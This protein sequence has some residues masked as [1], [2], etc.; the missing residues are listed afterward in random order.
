V[1]KNAKYF[2]QVEIS[3]HHEYAKVEHI[4][5][6]ADLLYDK[7]VNV[8]ANVMIDPSA[9]EKCQGLVTMLR[10]SKRRWPIL[11]MAVH[12]DGESKYND[13]QLTYFKKKLK[14]IPNLFWWFTLKYAVRTKLW[15]I[16]DFKKKRVQD[17][18]FLLNGKNKFKGWQCNLGVDHI[19]LSMTGD[20]GGTCKEMIYNTTPYN[21][22]SAN[23]TEVFNPVIKPTVCSKDK[24][25]CGNEIAISKKVIP[26]I[27]G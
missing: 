9:F 25:L 7:K 4:I 26:I 12:F 11:V 22:Y 18:W 13:E 1:G 24:C 20:V 19:E 21:I 17:Y 10:A 6:V 5:Q 15:V 3:V 8:V 16:E 2:D 14:R 23:F 27:V